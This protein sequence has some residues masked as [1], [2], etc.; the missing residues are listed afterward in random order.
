MVGR[1]R[2]RPFRFGTYDLNRKR[3]GGILRVNG[4]STDPVT[5]HDIPESD[6]G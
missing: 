2:Y 5:Q 3:D 6:C 4:T 1:Q